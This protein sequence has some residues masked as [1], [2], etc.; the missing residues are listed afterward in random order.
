M[1]PKAVTER[2]SSTQ[3]W[4]KHLW[5]KVSQR[6]EGETGLIDRLQVISPTAEG[7]RTLRRRLRRAAVCQR[8]RRHGRQP[9]TFPST[10]LVSA[11]RRWDSI[12]QRRPARHCSSR[13]RT[14]HNSLH[15]TLLSGSVRG[16]IGKTVCTCRSTTSSVLLSSRF[17]ASVALCLSVCPFLGVYLT[18][19]LTRLNLC[20]TRLVIFAHFWRASL[21]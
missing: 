16:Y 7:R 20:T 5:S 17:F 2:M 1:Q 15:S 12:L 11:W 8:P 14:R 13:R 19:S 6:S 3:R 18:T 21:Y 9:F 10:P 4:R